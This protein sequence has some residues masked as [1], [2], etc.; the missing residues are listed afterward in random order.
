MV[1]R[2]GI[3]QGAATRAR[4]KAPLADALAAVLKGKKCPLAKRWR[5]AEGWI[6]H[7]FSQLPHDGYHPVGN[8]KRIKRVERGV[9]TAA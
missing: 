6:P 2:G 9:Y 3:G 8:R 4:N 5:P 7:H 1:G